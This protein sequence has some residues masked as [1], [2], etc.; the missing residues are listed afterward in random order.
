MLPI[1]FHNSFKTNMFDNIDEIFMQHVA[2]IYP[3]L[4]PENF[5]VRQGAELEGMKYELQI[6]KK[7]D[8][9]E[10][11]VVLAAWRA[12]SEKERE[13]YTP[14]VL[15]G[16][17]KIIHKRE[18]G[19]TNSKI[20]DLVKNHLTEV[21]DFVVK[22][23]NQFELDKLKLSSRMLIAQFFVELGESLQS[24]EP[25]PFFYWVKI[26]DMQAFRCYVNTTCKDLES[27][28]QCNKL[29]TID[30]TKM[31]PAPMCEL[32]THVLRQIVEKKIVD[33]CLFTIVSRCEFIDQKAVHTN[34][35]PPLQFRR[36]FPKFG[37]RDLTSSGSNS[38]T[39]PTSPRRRGAMSPKLKDDRSIVDY[40]LETSDDSHR[41]SPKTEKTQN[42]V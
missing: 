17:V 36:S 28:I 15:L 21:Y 41:N 34:L 32:P 37:E 2:S 14:I 4:D 35:V 16:K 25:S 3:D 26:N 7:N 6:P 8:A 29:I 27:A 20:K 12:L 24:K 38:P 13:A 11:L 40:L 9:L 33:L 39:T 30:K 31:H 18:L 22:N 23:L 10:S 42:S 5:V 19:R 1:S